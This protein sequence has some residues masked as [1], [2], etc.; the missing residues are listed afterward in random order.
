MSAPGEAPLGAPSDAWLDSMR[1]VC[2]PIVDDVVGGYVEAASKKEIGALIG[3]LFREGR[4]DETHPLVARYSAAL[5]ALPEPPIGE[6]VARGQG[7]F[8]LFGPE[9]LL[10]LGSFAVP[11]AYA[12]ANGVQVIHRARRLEDD[13]IRRL[14]DT[15]QMVVNVM[16]V[17]GL[18]RGGI[19]WRSIRKVRL[20]HS[21][22]RFNA[23]KDHEERD[24]QGKSLGMKPWREN[25]G[26]PINQ[27]DQAG[28]L[29]T[30]SIGAIH[31]LR[32]MGAR[33]SKQTADDYLAA[34]AAVGRLLGVDERLIP[35]DELVATELARRIGERQHHHSKEGARLMVCLLHAVDSLFP[36]K[37]YGL[38]LSHFFLGSTPE[39]RKVIE[40]L[41]LPKPNW[42][43]FLVGARATQ[44]RLVLKLLEQVPGAKRRRS[45]LARRFTQTMILFKRPEVAG[46]FEV[47]PEL[48]VRWGIPAKKRPALKPVP[49]PP[50]GA[51]EP[52][53]PAPAPS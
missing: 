21:L 8:S 17:G 53:P 51:A 47:P 40:A 32:L 39:G 15:A 46:P 48:L 5:D 26:R 36:F 20:I 16:Q 38:S 42:T 2:D 14:C 33:I 24:E 44:K 23:L 35:V 45:F 25:W 22:M 11:L 41:R 12:A 30:F 10:T 18:A 13:P 1:D 43:R 31:G 27:E 19:G 7:L 50:P 6:A 9:I 49:C 34:W 29:L 37:G 4:L 3:T 52:P 28:T